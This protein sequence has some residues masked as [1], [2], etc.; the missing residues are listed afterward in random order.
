MK[1]SHELR[2]GGVA[3]VAAVVVALIGRLVMGNVPQI[4]ESAMTISGYLVER[5]AQVLA[6]ALLY[7]IATALFLWFGVALA[8]VFRRSDETSDAPAMVLAG[9]IVL[10]ATGFIGISVFAGMTYAVTTHRP[11]LAIAAGPYISLTVMDAIMGIALAVPF[12]ASAAAIMR[13]HVFPQWMAWCAIIVAVVSVLGAFTVAITGGPLAPGG[14]LVAFVPGVLTAL[15]VLAA[16]WLLIRE[17]LPIPS[18]GVRP[19]MGH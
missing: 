19:V 1:E 2:W 10:A 6:A 4:T 12:G 18:A 14:A 11:L 17:H 5:R 3:G 7:A 9:Y 13:T 16:S 8:T 15:W